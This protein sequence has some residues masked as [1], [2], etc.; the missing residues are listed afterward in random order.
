MEHGP[1]STYLIERRQEAAWAVLTRVVIAV[2][3]G[4]P[5][6]GFLGLLLGQVRARLSGH[7]SLFG[8]N[9]AVPDNRH[10]DVGVTDLVSGALPYHQQ[11]RYECDN[12]DGNHNRPYVK[13]HILPP[14]PTRTAARLIG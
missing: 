12:R 7:G 13:S 5:L 2:D 11:C 1:K 3:V 14:A 6:E 8:Y 9:R 4:R 10:L